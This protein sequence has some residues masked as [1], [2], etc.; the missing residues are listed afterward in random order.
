[1]SIP[2]AGSLRRGTFWWKPAQ[3][4]A[5]RRA[6]DRE[7]ARIRRRADDEGYRYV[8]PASALNGSLR[9]AW[10]LIIAGPDCHRCP[11]MR[12]F[13]PTT[14][15]PWPPRA[16]PYPD[17]AVLP[18]EHSRAAPVGIAAARRAGR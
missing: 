12:A 17:S 6:T 15:P 16:E 7:K 13:G 3:I 18:R 5:A 14:L 10:L 8:K 11:R 4:E 2:A 9:R 1:M